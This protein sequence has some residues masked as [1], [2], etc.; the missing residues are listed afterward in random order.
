[1]DARTPTTAIAD[2]LEAPRRYWAWAAIL[3]A[4]TLAVLDGAIANVALPTIAAEFQATPSVSIWIVNGYQ[5]AIVVSLLPLSALGEIYGYRRVYLTGIAVFTL[6]SV[7]CMLADS[8]G[9]L[10]AAR[11]VQGL[12]AAGLMSVNTALLRYTVP[13]RRFGAAIGLN[14]LTV[15]AASTVGPTLAGFILTWASWPWLFAI[16]VPLGVAAIAMGWASLP[17]SDRSDRPFD[18]K[19]AVLSAATMGLFIT[20]IDSIG[21]RLPLQWIV[22]QA[23][24]LGIAGTLLVRREL[25]MKDPMLPL[26]LLKLPI[27]SLSIATSVASFVAQ[28]L[29]FIS[30]PFT[31]QTIMGFS[32]RDVGLLMVPWPLAIAVAAPIAGR[33]SDRHS[34]ALLGGAGLVLLATGLT[35]LA[36]LPADASVPDIVWRMVLCGIGFGLFQ[37]PNNRTMVGAA[38]KRR[39]GA[40]SGMLSTARLTGQTTGAALV[41]SLLA[42]LGISGATWALGVGAGFAALAALLSLSRIGLFRKAEREAEAA[43]AAAAKRDEDLSQFP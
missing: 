18:W 43:A 30:L 7:A 24:A 25:G 11:V 6:A 29:A 22:G 8:L 10:T 21:H 42:H 15:A 1:L 27:F 34:P 41:A 38:P 9:A 2:G 5:L 26:D 23:V 36:V 13:A 28:M 4:L 37:T 20:L 35:L 32:P 31:L 12:G 14:A 16:N 3:V 33:L 39:S 17:D 40:A 19:S